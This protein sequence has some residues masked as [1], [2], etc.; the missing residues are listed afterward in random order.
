[1]LKAINKIKD[2]YIF[3]ILFFFAVSF[4][5]NLDISTF[6]LIL[7]FFF[8]LF[9]SI[10]NTKSLKETFKNP[11]LY[12]TSITWIWSFFGLLYSSNIEH[13]L[14]I[15][16][17]SSCM[18]LLA[19]FFP[20][21]KKRNLLTIED[22]KKIFFGFVISSTSCAI[23]CFLFSFI[24][25]LFYSETN[26]WNYTNLVHVKLSPGSLGNYIVFSLAI[27]ILSLMNIKPFNKQKKRTDV[28][29][30]ILLIAINVLFLFLL[31]AKAAIISFIFIYTFIRHYNYYLTY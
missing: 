28:F 27:L 1:M 23:F 16:G 7:L 15:I 11:L 30:L 6:L 2:N 13:G 5:W 31:Q 10:G 8:W 4:C 25:E 19:V 21:I 24:N 29:L 3:Y 12:L 17:V 14:F 18:F 9:D 22:L 20:S 26:N